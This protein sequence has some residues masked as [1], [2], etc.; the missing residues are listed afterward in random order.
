M[1]TVP[2]RSQSDCHVNYF[3]FHEGDKNKPKLGLEKPF[4]V[5]NLQPASPAV[6]PASFI[7]SL[8]SPSF[9]SFTV[10]Q[11]I[12]LLP[13]SCCDLGGCWDWFVFNILPNLSIFSSRLLLLTTFNYPILYRMTQS[14]IQS[15]SETSVT[16][17]LGW[18]HHTHGLYKSGQWE[19]VRQFLLILLG[20]QHEGNRP[21]PPPVIAALL[22][23]WSGMCTGI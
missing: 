13:N 12:L 21:H 3:T 11:A 20:V 4:H 10:T 19:V 7:Q 18:L 15:R 22:S 2:I 14:W 8:T 5:L 23:Q 9:L 16:L 6:S 17:V 1:E